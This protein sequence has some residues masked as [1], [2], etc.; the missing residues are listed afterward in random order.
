MA[1]N[2]N[3]FN[4][5]NYNSIFFNNSFYSSSNN[6]TNKSSLNS[7]LNSYG[8][9]NAN[10]LNQVAQK[11]V[12][13]SKVYS[14]N[15]KQSINNLMNRTSK[16][17]PVFDKKTAESSNKEAVEIKSTDIK[18]TQNTSQPV[19]VKVEQVAT[20]QK[21]TGETLVSNEKSLDAKYYQFEISSNGK[22]QQVSFS[23]SNSDNNEAVQRKIAEAINSKNTGVSASV[24]Y[25]S[26]T[27]SSKIVL[28]AK[29][30]GTGSNGSNKFEVR[31]V[32]GN[33]ALQM[34]LSNVSQQAKDAI[35]SINGEQKT[36]KSND[37]ALG[38]GVTATLKKA[39][40]DE[41]V[42][43]SI[44]SDTGAQIDKV[45]EMVNNFNGLLEAADSN[46][47]D[48][49]TKKLSNELRT[50][51]KTYMSSLNRIG[52]SFNSNGYLAID[53]DKMDKAANDGTLEKFFKQD[54]NSSYGFANRVSQTASKVNNNPMT[55]VGKSSV[56]P[57]LSNPGFSLGNYYNSGFMQNNAFSMYSG[58]LFD[59][60]F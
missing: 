50:T 29:E 38:N 59:G 25:D 3:S 32:S 49:S 10:Y 57:Q 36:S 13:D 47:K 55:Y 1:I 24:S 34:G 16:E 31:D 8:K 5:G 39:T 18:K 4:Y 7:I 20:T 41:S 44:K 26:K 46:S 58:L 40:G 51:A 43:V 9:N 19:D 2:T 6:M 54:R 48:S 17:Q 23:V 35:F 53:K 37:V 21:N 60:F 27:K 14:Q 22:T 11:F 33:A 15:L 56:N 28:E 12:T 52:I 42:K 30:T 45:R